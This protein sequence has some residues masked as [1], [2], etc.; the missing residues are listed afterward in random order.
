LQTSS[1][2]YFS[3]KATDNAGNVTSAI[4]SNG[5]AV[6]PTLAFSIDSTTITFNNLNSANG[7]TDTQTNLLTTS[8]NAYGGYS[9]YAS[10]TQLL[11]S[12]EHPSRTIANYSGT[13]A[14][15]TAWGAGVYGFG[16]T[17]YDTSVQGSNRFNNGNNFAAFPLTSPG[18]IV[19]DHTSF[20][21][22]STGMVNN[23][24][25]MIRYKVM[26]SV[27]QAATTYTAKVNYIITANY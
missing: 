14:S 21:N 2:Y 7:W 25:F 3:V 11:T 4:N 10:L 19:A 15:P 17:S 22:G 27:I 9:I 18:D 8:T 6:N 24:Q 5:Q 20:V 12:S 23:E 13:W 16:Y 26:V 1:N